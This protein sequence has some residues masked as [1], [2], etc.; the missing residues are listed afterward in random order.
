[1]P[2]R[3]SFYA[4]LFLCMSAHAAWSQDQ[5]N[6]QINQSTLPVM[7]DSVRA[8]VKEN[9]V[10]IAWSNLTERDVDFYQVERSSNAKDFKP[11]IRISPSSNLNDKAAYAFTDQH[12]LDGNNYYRIRVTIISG[13]IITSRVLKAITG[14]STP[15]LTV[16]PNPVT[17]ERFNV[18]LAAVQKG[19]YTLGLTNG[20]GVLVQQTQLSLQGEG[21]T[22][23]VSL[24]AGLKAGVYVLS[25]K[26]EHYTASKLILLNRN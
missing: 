25:V 12:P 4:A 24:P 10:Q 26:G 1:M 13:K 2:L 14:F 19:R 7:F 16:Y 3:K 21:I 8:M 17:E 18:S 11:I 6:L 23:P 22:Q 15:G 20:A 9:Q 5:S